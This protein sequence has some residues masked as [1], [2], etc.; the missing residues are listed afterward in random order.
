MHMTF[1]RSW[2]KIGETGWYLEDD[3]GLRNVKEILKIKDNN[4]V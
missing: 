1:S 2:T 3:S 4:I